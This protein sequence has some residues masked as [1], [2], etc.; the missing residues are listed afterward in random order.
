MFGFSE[1][2]STTPSRSKVSA[3]RAIRWTEACVLDTIEIS[4]TLF[5]LIKTVIFCWMCLIPLCLLYYH[6]RVLISSIFPSLKCRIFGLREGE[7]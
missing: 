4:K 6:V 1:G 2:K 5:G 3:Y 7:P